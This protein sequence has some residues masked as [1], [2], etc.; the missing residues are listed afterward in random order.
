MS[1][2]KEKLFTMVVLAV[3]IFAIVFFAENVTFAKGQI[4]ETEYFNEDLHCDTCNEQISKYELANDV[5]QMCNH[6]HMIDKMLVTGETAHTT[7]TNHV[8]YC[9]ECGYY[10]VVCDDETFNGENYN[11]NCE[12]DR[13]FSNYYNNLVENGYKDAG[14]REVKLKVLKE[15]DD[16]GYKHFYEFICMDHPTVVLEYK[17]GEFYCKDCQQSQSVIKEVEKDD[18]EPFKKEEVVERIKKQ[19]KAYEGENTT[20]DESHYAFQ[21][22]VKEEVKEP[23]LIENIINFFKDLF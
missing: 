6:E 18:N 15:L 22:E 21:R 19:A 3:C 8:K 4:E 10:E 7:L 11:K 12:F 9:P 13:A 5:I 2:F 14:V 23:N 20:Q 16:S 1:N 17:D